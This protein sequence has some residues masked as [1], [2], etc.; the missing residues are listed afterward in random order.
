MKIKLASDFINITALQWSLLR[1]ALVNFLDGPHPSRSDGVSA[2]QKVCNQKTSFSLSEAAA[3]CIALLQLRDLLRLSPQVS[4]APPPPLDS[5]E[6][7]PALD[8]LI[9][10]LQARL[11]AHG[12]S[13]QQVQ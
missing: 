7:L 4:D 6:A 13:I 11:S 2:Y 5:A 8:S 10:R 1:A 12:V 3:I 9:S